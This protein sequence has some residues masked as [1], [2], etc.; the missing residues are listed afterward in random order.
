MG[1]LCSSNPKDDAIKT[2]EKVE[3]KAE[4]DEADFFE[5]EPSI[6][7]LGLD[8]HIEE[9]FDKKSEFYRVFEEQRDKDLVKFSKDPCSEHPERV[10]VAWKKD[11]STG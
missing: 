7:V 11:G 6:S 1:G 3:A 9:H 2:K 10:F 5:R 8:E 4:K